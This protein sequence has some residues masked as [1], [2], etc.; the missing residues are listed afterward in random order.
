MAVRSLGLGG[1]A[2]YLTCTQESQR[3][4]HAWDNIS[5]AELWEIPQPSHLLVQSLQGCNGILHSPVLPLGCPP[6]LEE[7]HDKNGGADVAPHIRLHMA[8]AHGL[9]GDATQQEEWDFEQGQHTWPASLISTKKDTKSMSQGTCTLRING[10]LVE[11]IGAYHWLA[12]HKPKP[13][14]GTP[15]CT[16]PSWVG[17]QVPCTCRQILSST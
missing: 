3:R 14:V 11:G 2:T 15:A 9:N 1:A 5:G 7:V 16:S 12:W 10:M 4:N 8:R 6:M 17:C 13:Q